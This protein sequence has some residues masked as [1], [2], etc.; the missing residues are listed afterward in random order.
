MSKSKLTVTIVT[1]IVFVAFLIFGIVYYFGVNYS[2]FYA[3]A[4][5]EFEIQGLEDGFTP[6][7]LAYDN[8]NHFLVSGYMDDG[9]ASRIYVVNSETN[10]TEKCV[11]LYY[12]NDGTREIYTGH[13]GGIVSYSDGVWVVGDGIVNF[14]SY[15]NLMD[16]KDGDEI[17]IESYFQAHN[18]ADFITTYQNRLVVGEFY[19][20]GSHEVDTTHTI[21]TPSG[22]INTAVTFLYDI[23]TVNTESC[24]LQDYIPEKAISTTSLVQGMVITDDEIIISASYSLP[25]SHIYT[26]DNFL[27]TEGVS[28][29]YSGLDEPVPTYILDEA[30]SDLVAPCMAEEIAVKDGRLYVLFESACNQYKLYTRENIKYVYSYDLN[31]PSP[32]GVK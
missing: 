29:E 5:Q 22:K 25:S 21:E 28:V 30:T 11:T 32:V 20:D 1:I 4:E 15:Q 18:G 2:D 31:T 27:N 10:E 9:S 24:G 12:D 3:M 14:F 17:L 26:Y 13:C 8:N 23:N 19:R 6:Q 16:A 7:G